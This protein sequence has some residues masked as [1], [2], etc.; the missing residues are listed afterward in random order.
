[1]PSKLQ[2]TGIDAERGRADLL[3]RTELR[4][5]GLV[6]AG[7]PL[8][9]LL[10][11]IVLGFEA[12]C[13]EMIGSVLL[14]DPK[15]K[16]LWLGAAPHLPAEYNAIADG[17]AIGP[18]EG[19]CGT[20]AYLRERVI[21]SDI[22]TDPRW[23]KYK[24]IA[25]RFG[26]AASWSEPILDQAGEVAG[27][28]AMYYRAPRAPTV[29]EM[30]LI[31]IGAKLASIAIA[32]SRAEA[33]LRASEERLRGALAAARMGTWEWNVATGEVL[34]S[35]GVEAVFG[36]PEGSFGATHEAYVRAIDDLD[37]ARVVQA[38]DD[39]LAGRAPEYTAEHRV[40]LPDGSTRW[41]EGK[42]TVYRDAAGAPLRLS[43]TVADI[44]ARKETEAALRASEALVGQSRKMQA[45]GRLAGGIAHDFNNLLTVINASSKMALRRV[46]PG[47]DVDLLLAEIVQAGDRAADLTR[48]LL[49]FSRQRSLTLETIDLTRAVEGG[50]ALL[51]RALGPGVELVMALEPDLGAVGAEAGQIER[52]VMNLAVN[53]RDAMPG[54][55][56]L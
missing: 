49:A 4:V 33:A 28:F 12:Q 9:K 52:I 30:G 35:R 27:T 47:N 41:L 36:L 7:E 48:Q 21:V 38:L 10:A 25:A 55:G 24:D 31:E 37:R 53:A 5:L 11:T 20:A 6:A 19:S 16:R 14:F 3:Q 1:M 45:I 8:S 39:A 34:W 43:G 18:F 54:G 32:R 51:Q 26:L 50:R 29:W 44:T 15:E 46:T 13:P 17:H 42:G 56:R 22:A 40:R 23:A 2:D